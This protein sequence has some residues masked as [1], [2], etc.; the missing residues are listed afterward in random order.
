MPYIRILSEYIQYKFW[1]D[2][3]S[4]KV[5]LFLNDQNIKFVPKS[6]N[7]QNTPEMQCIEDFWGL[8]NLDQLRTMILY[9]FKKVDQECVQ[10]LGESTRRQIDTIK[11]F[12][13]V[14]M[15]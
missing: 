5:V 3:Y 10:N 13:L 1:P 2:Y 12:C 4:K 7:P 9:C 11:R 14:E 6:E 15:R 8:I